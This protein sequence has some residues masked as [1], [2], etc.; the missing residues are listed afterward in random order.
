VE[1][2]LFISVS[3]IEAIDGERI[4]AAHR[5]TLIV[6]RSFDA[7]N[8]RST[9]PS[10]S[11]RRALPFRNKRRDVLTIAHRLQPLEIREKI[12][13]FR[14]QL[15]AVKDF[16]PSLRRCC[17][18]LA[19]QLP[20]IALDSVVARS[21]WTLRVFDRPAT[22]ECSTSQPLLYRPKPPREIM[23]A[24]LLVELAARLV[25]ES[26]DPPP[27]QETS[28]ELAKQYWTASKCRLES[29][30]RALRI[31]QEDLKEPDPWHDPWPATE[32]VVQEIFVSELLTR[33]WS[34]VLIQRDRASQSNE[35]TGVAQ[36]VYISHMEIS[37]QALRLLLAQPSNRNSEVEKLN[38]LRRR[39]ERWTDLLLACLPEPQISVRVA[40]DRQRMQEFHS[41]RRQQSPE[42]QRQANQILLASLIADLKK[43]TNR[44]SANPELNRQIAAGVITFLPADRFDSIGLPKSPSQMWIEQTLDESDI[45]LQEFQRL[46]EATGERSS[47]D[48]RAESRWRSPFRRQ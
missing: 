4:C 31:F 12:G 11:R 27:A 28:I 25:L 24:R 48:D 5:R 17:A 39:V 23:H 9:P 42:T 10:G 15:P 7:D 33:V 8:L 26:A 45:Y 22:T 20:L 21:P 30:Q 38:S 37:S 46:C 6:S 14:P 13:R 47:L 44:L 18:A 32:V 36:S 41:E 19:L 1:D 34:A 40:H 35:L 43:N 29:W 2:W 16:A 3:S